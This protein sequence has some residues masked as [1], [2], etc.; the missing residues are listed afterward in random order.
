MMR[1]S[2]VFFLAVSFAVFGFGLS[3]KCYSCPSG[4][5]DDC[6]DTQ[7]CNHG[8]D[9]CLQLTRGGKTY[10]KCMRYA[11]CDFMTLA[12][13]YGF[14]Q[15]TFSCCQSKLCNGDQQDSFEIL[16]KESS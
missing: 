4:S 3:L 16:T 11:D 12:A 2:V 6:D 8:D 1:S 14:P 10:T 5:S 15:F 13:S 7:E 9:S